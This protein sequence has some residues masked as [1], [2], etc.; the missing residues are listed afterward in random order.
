MTKFTYYTLSLMLST[1]TTILFSPTLYLDNIYSIIFILSTYF[2]IFKNYSPP[3]SGLE[4]KDYKVNIYVN[5]SSSTYGYFMAFSAFLCCLLFFVL[6]YYFK[7]RLFFAT[8]FTWVIIDTILFFA[9]KHYG[10]IEKIL[11]ENLI[12]YIQSFKKYTIN[13]HILDLTKV[14]SKQLIQIINSKE[15][16]NIVNVY[17]DL[18]SIIKLEFSDKINKFENIFDDCFYFSIEFL[19]PSINWEDIEEYK[20]LIKTNNTSSQNNK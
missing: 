11:T 12:D 10:N 6:I 13:Q 15:N 1:I 5:K 8:F 19:L 20:K 4:E 17:N 7:V 2:L 3:P 18:K 14:F 16:Q 9:I